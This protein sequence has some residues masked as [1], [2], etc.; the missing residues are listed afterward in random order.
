MGNS[1]QAGWTET[2]YTDGRK[3]LDWQSRY[4]A[5]KKQ[6]YG[7]A[8]Y[9]FSVSVIS[10]VLIF[11]T[12]AF[13]CNDIGIEEGCSCTWPVY[14]KYKCLFGYMSA[15]LA[16]T[17]GGC[18]Y[19]IKWLYHSV[20]KGIWNVDRRLW[21]LLAPHMSGLVALFTAFLIASGLFK[22][23]DEDFI[24]LP[25]QIIGFSFLVGYFSD[26]AIAKMAEISDTLFGTHKNKPD[27]SS[28]AAAQKSNT[29]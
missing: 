20:A 21:R 18:L 5:A 2:D 4:P 10:V 6:I 27:D 28:D 16:G 22:V 7:E 29:P 8:I 25:F 14:T 1:P 19:D 9:L 11:V 15:Y 26:K 3:D 23:L 17:V 13:Y 12:L 24:E